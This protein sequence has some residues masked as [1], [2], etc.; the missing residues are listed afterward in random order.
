MDDKQIQSLLDK[1][2]EGETTLQEEKILGEYFRT[3]RNVKAEW[4]DYK[5]MFEYFDQGMPYEQPEQK[6]SR[7]GKVVKMIVGA[8]SAAAIAALLFT[9]ALPEGNDDKQLAANDEPK[10]EAPA[11]SDNIKKETSKEESVDAKTEKKEEAPAIK[12]KKKRAPRIRYSIPAPQEYMAKNEKKDT[13]NAVDKELINSYLYQCAAMDLA[14]DEI[15]ETEMNEETTN[16][17]NE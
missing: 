4:K 8:I 17:I 7:F 1:F 11:K 2:M 15:Y 5:S 16:V 13:L 14:M 3:T 10:K 6:V 9:F 12:S